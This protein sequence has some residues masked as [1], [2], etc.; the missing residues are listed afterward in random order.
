MVREYLSEVVHI[1]E[2]CN[3]VLPSVVNYPPIQLHMSIF[4]ASIIYKKR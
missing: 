4:S 1:E 2:L 3:K